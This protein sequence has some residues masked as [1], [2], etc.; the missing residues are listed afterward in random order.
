MELKE[1]ADFTTRIVV[2]AL[3]SGQMPA[4]TSTII[5]CYEAVYNTIADCD[6]KRQD[7]RSFNH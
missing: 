4:E 3:Q 2:A 5:S 7:T 1:I 6:K